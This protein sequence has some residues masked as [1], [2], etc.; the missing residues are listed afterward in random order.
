MTPLLLRP[1]VLSTADNMENTQQNNTQQMIQPESTYFQPP[2]KSKNATSNEENMS[3]NAKKEDT[4][5]QDN[6]E[7]PNVRNQIPKIIL[8]QTHPPSSSMYQSPRRSHKTKQNIRWDPS[9]IYAASQAKMTIIANRD[10]KMSAG[11]VISQELSELSTMHLDTYNTVQATST[12]SIFHQTELE[13]DSKYFHCT[14]NTNIN[15]DESRTKTNHGQMVPKHKPEPLN[16]ACT[17]LKSQ[18]SS[19]NMDIDYDDEDTSTPTILTSSRR[20]SRDSRCSDS[21]RPVFFMSEIS[22]T[23]P[24]AQE[25]KDKIDKAITSGSGYLQ[26]PTSTGRRRH[27]WMNR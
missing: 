15:I 20:Q 13:E 27:S 11:D 23:Q 25:I 8:H 14:S 9:T 18:E 6:P 4:T 3:I 21:D 7:G 10:R 1:F 12:P 17:N 19:N 24:H 26:I 22:D 2:T 5:V 16:L